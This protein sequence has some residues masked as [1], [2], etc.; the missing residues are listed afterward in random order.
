MNRLLSIQQFPDTAY[1]AGKL[2]TALKNDNQQID[3]ISLNLKSCSHCASNV[4]RL[5]L[6]EY[7]LKFGHSVSL[8]LIDAPQSLLLAQ[9]Y[10]KRLCPR[11]PVL[12][13]L[14]AGPLMEF[15]SI[16][17]GLTEKMLRIMQGISAV[18]L[19]GPSEREYA[20]LLRIPQNLC[21]EVKTPFSSY[22]SARLHDPKVVSLVADFSHA[23]TLNKTTQLIS[24][25]GSTLSSL[26]IQL[27]AE[28]QAAQS[29]KL[30]VLPATVLPAARIFVSDQ[31]NYDNATILSSLQLRI[32]VI[33]SD[34]A[35]FGLGLSHTKEYLAGN[36]PR[37]IKEK[38][39]HL[40]Q[41][42]ALAGRLKEA[43]Q[44]FIR[45]NH[46]DSDFLQTIPKLRDKLPSY[47]ALGPP[48]LD[49]TQAVFLSQKI[50][51]A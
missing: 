14:R 45:D 32:P 23:A 15:Q 35:A 25:L 41:N 22:I 49:Q 16:A 46:N 6:V 19:S 18:L 26:G 38:L 30:Q 34:A 2:A 7:L 42:P 12:V 8:I 9:S 17:Q 31:K 10:L 40:L 13:N 20:S 29:T 43:G 28:G 37:T 50:Q 36:H 5:T 21:L 48:L 33:A 47:S 39:S 24:L 27:F 4:L 3:V 51:N 11:A 1:R 44:A